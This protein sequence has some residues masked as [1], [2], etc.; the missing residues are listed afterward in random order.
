MGEKWKRSGQSIGRPIGPRISAARNLRNATGMAYEVS[1]KPAGGQAM[2]R[3]V[4]AAW[5]RVRS[6]GAGC[7]GISALIASTGVALAAPEACNAPPKTARH[8]HLPANDG[9]VHWGYLSRN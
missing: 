7:L 3:R 1:N 2:T 9:T 5:D 6:Y 8:H 4:G